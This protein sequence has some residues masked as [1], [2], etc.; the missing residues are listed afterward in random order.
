[1]DIAMASKLL[2]KVILQA[3][4]TLA[5]RDI[6]AVAKNTDR[7]SKEAEVVLKRRQ[8]T[9]AQ[10]DARIAELLKNEAVVKAR[11]DKII[12]DAVDKA[13]STSAEAVARFN[14]DEVRRRKAIADLESLKQIAMGDLEK[15]RG[16]LAVANKELRQA[17]GEKMT[18][19]NEKANIVESMKKLAGTVR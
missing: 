5:L 15:V 17:R 19:I 7:L 12:K 18:A 16:E 14:A 1:M 2:D 11:A 13:A 9:I 3:E 6:L 10:A 8:E 4:A